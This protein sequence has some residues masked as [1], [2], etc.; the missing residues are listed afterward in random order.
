MFYEGICR[1]SDGTLPPDFATPDHM[2][3]TWNELPGAACFKS[4]G[5]RVRLSRWWSWFDRAREVVLCW[6]IYALALVVLGIQRGWWPNV[7]ETP[8]EKQ[9]GAAPIDDGVEEILGDQA[10]GEDEP[11][12]VKAIDERIAQKRQD[13]ANTLHFACQVFAN[14]YV[15]RLARMCMCVQVPARA[16]VGED[17]IT[18]KTMAGTLELALD[19][20]MR[21]YNDMLRSTVAQMCNSKVMVEVGFALEPGDSDP[22]DDAMLAEKMFWYTL[23]LVG[24]F[25]TWLPLRSDSFPWAFALLLHCDNKVKVSAL[26]RFRKVW[27]LLCDYESEVGNGLVNSTLDGMLWPSMPWVREI[28]IALSETGWQAVPKHVEK[29]LAEFVKGWSNTHLSEQ[30]FQHLRGK[31]VRG[32]TGGKLG[33]K[34]AWH[35]ATTSGLLDAW[36]R[37]Q[38]DVTPEHRASASRQ[39]FNVASFCASKAALSLEPEHFQD[40]SSDTW[41]SPSAVRFP[42]MVWSTLVMEQCGRDYGKLAKNW[43]SQLFVKGSLVLQTSEKKYFMVL[44]VL[45]CG[46]LMWEVKVM[47]KGELF[48]FG[49][50]SNAEQPWVF[51]QCFDMKAWRAVGVKARPPSW[52]AAHV[53]GSATA[54]SMKILLTPK[55]KAMTLERFAA[56]RAFPGMTMPFLTKLASHLGIDRPARTEAKLLRE[57][58]VKVCPDFS[59]DT[60]E[61]CLK[62]RGRATAPKDPDASS[63]LSKD[64]SVWEAVAGLVDEEEREDVKKAVQRMLEEK[65]GK[66]AAAKPKVNLAAVGPDQAAPVAA[67]SS[68]SNSAAGSGPPPKRKIPHGPRRE[69]DVQY[70]KPP[71]K[72]CLLAKDDRR[73]MRWSASYPRQVPPR[74]RTKVWTIPG[75]DE[76]RSLLYCTQWLW[77]C[78][79]EATGQE[80]P[81]DLEEFSLPPQ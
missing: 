54:S 21:K 72:G 36:G 8:F 2:R 11:R 55:G 31:E 41:S 28:F 32:D 43:Q 10:G 60:I 17:M 13:T 76:R 69:S 79:R 5:T 4:K 24:A 48:F 62:D 70:L 80:C 1:D 56:S 45:T 77:L 38:V 15:R 23:S 46:A 59:E 7:W 25:L 18:A 12:S 65:H 34:K 20:G 51:H 71:V 44:E 42:Y 27:E 68:G 14:D 57:L 63:L 66:P 49:F 39:S 29:S 33:P 47:R 52:V 37:P 50:L 26:A 6:H 16:R 81:F 64:M 40:L 78:H 73:F 35:Y 61:A 67:S 30:I 19:N 74:M 58:I 22:A 3:R 9:G 75:W 53:S